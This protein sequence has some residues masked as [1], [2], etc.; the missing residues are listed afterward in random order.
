MFTES[1]EDSNIEIKVAS[2]KAITSFLSSI[3]EEETVLK[4]KALSEKLLNVVI[5][6][7]QK[8]ETQ[9]QASLEFMIELTQTHP[10][11]WGNSVPMLI[12]V[13][14]EVMKNREFEDATR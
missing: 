1:L 4:Y 8:D 9:G 10:D 2:L 13:I 11:I 5:D 12:F 7:M 14:S 3:D 6:V